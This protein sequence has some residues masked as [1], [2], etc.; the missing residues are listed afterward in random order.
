MVVLGC[1]QMTLEEVEAV[2]PRFT[3]RRLTKRTLFHVQ[4]D[5][6]AAL[7][8]TPL[9]EE[10]VR[11]GVEFHTHCPLA[12]LTVRLTPGSWQVL[13]NSGKL[14]YYLAHAAY[15]TTSDLAVAG[16]GDE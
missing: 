14:H 13:T 11:A 3:G 4:P 16:G 10:L 1:P 6:C 15:G 9:Y 12:G 8:K 7:Q 5:A 2:A